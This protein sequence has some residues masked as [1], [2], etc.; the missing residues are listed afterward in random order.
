MEKVWGPIN[1]FYIAV[2]ATPVADGDR[3]AAYAKVC[4]T[5]PESYWDADCA[6]KLFGGEYHPTGEAAVSAMALEAR[7]EISHL[8][9]YARSLAERRQRD[10]IQIP[11]L[12]V[13]TFFRHRVAA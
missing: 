3:W 5:R 2:Y 13:G 1:G 6:F 7:N 8:P 12:V 4:W 11:R 10:H 9:S